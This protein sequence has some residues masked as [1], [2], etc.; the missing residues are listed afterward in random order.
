MSKSGVLACVAAI[1]GGVWAGSASTV[2]A[3]AKQ[4]VALSSAPVL[5]PANERLEDDSWNRD[6]DRTPMAWAGIGLK[7]GMA[8]MGSGAYTV[9]DGEGDSYT[10]RIGKRQGLHLALPISLGGDG[11]GWTIE[12]FY[13]RSSMDYAITNV[14]LEPVGSET[15]SLSAYGLYTGPVYNIH[16][17]DPL[18]VGVGLGVKAA[19]IKTNAFDYAGDAYGRMPLSATYYFT[20]Q[21]A[22]VAE[23]GLGYGLSVLADKSVGANLNREAQSY[24]KYGDDPKFGT[25]FAWDFS[26]GVRLP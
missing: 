14:F 4:A 18:Y 10:G 7:V 16:I 19:Y 12:P 6:R 26:V 13:A 8:G 20:N 22:V 1:V 23:L 3:Q 2:E 15:A 21:L 11:F 5:Q 17:I 25:A 24:D 9:R